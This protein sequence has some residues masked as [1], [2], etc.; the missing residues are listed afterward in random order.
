MVPELDKAERNRLKQEIVAEVLAT[1]RPPI[2][3][4]AR[5]EIPEK[6][7]EPTESDNQQPGQTS[8]IEEVRSQRQPPDRQSEPPR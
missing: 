6:I 5:E 4:V 8:S 7:P 2:D 1:I 3:K